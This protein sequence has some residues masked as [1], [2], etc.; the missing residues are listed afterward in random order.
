MLELESRLARFVGGLHQDR[1]YRRWALDD[2][3]Q[4]ARLVL[5][6][7]IRLYR[8]DSAASLWTYAR[9]RIEGYFMDK[10]RM[11]ARRRRLSLMSSREHLSTEG[12]LMSNV[13][14]P[15]GTAPENGNLVSA[16]AHMIELRKKNPADPLL[17]VLY[18]DLLR[19]LF[20]ELQSRGLAN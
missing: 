5:L 15:C 11:E 4:D 7:R 19:R 12:E 1:R 20:G 9:Y 13:A 8:K 3:M 18:Q 2:M 6:T 17:D 10:H 16:T 14:P